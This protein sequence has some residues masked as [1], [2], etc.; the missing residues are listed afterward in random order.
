[1]RFSHPM[2]KPC[3][4]FTGDASKY[5]NVEQCGS[6]EKSTLLSIS[7]QVD[8]QFK[9]P[10]PKPTSIW[11]CICGVAF[12]SKRMLYI[13][14]CRFVIHAYTVLYNIFVFFSSYK[15]FIWILTYVAYASFH[16]SRKPI[17]VVKVCARLFSICLEL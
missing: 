6:D 15:V 8:K 13:H 10:S 14:T 11:Y 16:I 1:M 2:V 5:D 7:V 12:S 17:S 4:L 3:E 9:L